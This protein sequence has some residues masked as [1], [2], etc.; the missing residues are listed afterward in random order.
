MD[1]C[2]SKLQTIDW[3]RSNRAWVGRVL[4]ENGKVQNSEEAIALTSSYI[5]HQ[6]GVPLTKEEQ[7]KEKQILEIE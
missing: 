3:L 1:S 2:L 5:K 4:R 6:I 7:Q